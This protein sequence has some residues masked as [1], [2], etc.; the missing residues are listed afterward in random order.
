MI[1]NCA[2]TVVSDAHDVHDHELYVKPDAWNIYP[3]SS[4]L[5]G[6]IL[7]T[8]AVPFSTNCFGKC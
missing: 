3:K 8:E 2:A 7:V 4:N 5:Q 6:M 1:T